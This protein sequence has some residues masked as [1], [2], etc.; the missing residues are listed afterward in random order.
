MNLKVHMKINYLNQIFNIHVKR[1][2]KLLKNVNICTIEYKVYF[3]T[4]LKSINF[5]GLNFLKLYFCIYVF[6]IYHMFESL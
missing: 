1:K 6:L 3:Q 4:L 2:K 5:F